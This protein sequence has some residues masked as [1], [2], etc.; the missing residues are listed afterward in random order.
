MWF[1]REGEFPKGENGMITGHSRHAR[2]VIR[3]VVARLE[4]V[5]TCEDFP[6]DVIDELRKE[7]LDV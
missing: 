5:D 6:Y 7:Y 2:E 3:E 1:V 4:E